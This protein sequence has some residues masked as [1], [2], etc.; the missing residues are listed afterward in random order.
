MLLISLASIL[1][2][3]AMAFTTT[4]TRLILGYSSVAQLGFITLGIFSLR[5]RGRPGRDPAGGQ[6]RPRR[7]A[8]C[9]SSSGCS[10]RARGGSEDMRDMGGI[11]FRA[12]VLATL[13]LIVDARD[14]R[15]AGLVEL[16]RRVPDPARRL[17]GEDRVRDHRLRRRR[18]G[19][20]LRA[21]AVHPRDAQPRRAERRVARDDAS[22][23]ASCSCR[24]CSR[25][26]LFALYPQLALKQGSRPSGRPAPSPR[27]SRRRPPPSRRGVADERRADARPGEGPGPARSTG[28]GCRRCSRCSAARPS[29]CWSACSARASSARRSCRC[30]RSRRSARRSGSAIWQWDADSRTSSPARCASTS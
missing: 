7:R 1:Y 3:S 10:R 26:S 17:Q 18:D 4:N 16:R 5:P 2:G 24:S 8:R 20:R 21:A 27:R 11:A 29:C 28:R 15:D 12:P 14:A 22:P 9:S 25:S 19:E 6:P 23:T 13:F 30:W